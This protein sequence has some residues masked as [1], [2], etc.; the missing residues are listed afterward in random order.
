MPRATLD[1]W[2]YKLKTMEICITKHTEDDIYNHM[3]IMY[4]KMK[5]LHSKYKQKLDDIMDGLQHDDKNIYH[6]T[7]YNWRQGEPSRFWLKNA[8]YWYYV[9]LNDNDKETARNEV[10]LMFQIDCDFMMCDKY[11]P[12]WNTERPGWSDMLYDVNRMQID[13]KDSYD[14]IKVYEEWSFLECRAEW[15]AKDADF[16]KQKDLER[17]HRKNHP[18]IS[19]PVHTLY[20]NIIENE[21]IPYPDQ[22]LRDDCVHCKTHWE[23][24]K[25][26][27]DR[28]MAM[29]NKIIQEHEEYYRQKDLEEQKMKLKKEQQAKQ[30]AEMLAK[31]PKDSLICK[32]C[33]YEAYD[34]DD[35]D[36]HMESEDHKLKKRY[37]KI[38]NIQCKTDY[39]FN[40]H[41]ETIKH[42]K[43]AG[44]ID[45]KPKTYKCEHCDYETII[46]A[47]YERHIYSKH[48]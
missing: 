4:G 42:K 43:N 30:Y 26:N 48:K 28:A 31:K 15:M 25:A 39:D 37:C 29:R 34:D 23:T 16:I 22:P 2:T 6:Y 27:Y 14:H 7:N 19:L 20:D 33:Q 40:H 13:M 41:C 36:E 44:L 1:K 5:E 46:K 47:N 8:N 9:D 21:P 35:L 3:V 10:W 38:C 45:N 11:L 18:R 17:E 24:M 32:D 12:D